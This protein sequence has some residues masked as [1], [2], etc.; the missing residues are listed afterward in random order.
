MVG[1]KEPT[2][3]PKYICFFQANK[4]GKDKQAQ[5]QANE[6]FQRE[7]LME[8]TTHQLNITLQAPLY[9]QRCTLASPFHSP[10]LKTNKITSKSKRKFVFYCEVTD[11]M[12][13]EPLLASKAIALEA[14]PTL[15]VCLFTYAD[16]LNPHPIILALLR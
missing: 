13:E 5:L 7:W 1:T 3:L 14:G 16:L 4:E 6:E 2:Q 15:P 12:L 8:H 9:S 10:L 11:K